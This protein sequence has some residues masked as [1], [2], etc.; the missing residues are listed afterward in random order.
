MA[1]YDFDP[2][3]TGFEQP[4]TMTPRGQLAAYGGTPAPDYTPPT[5]YSTA[6]GTG[7]G[8]VALG[9]GGELP[10]VEAGVMPS[11]IGLGRQLGLPAAVM[12]ALGIAGGA[13]AGYQALGGGEGEGIFGMDVL[14]GNG[15][16]IPGTQIGLGGP[17]LAEPGPGTG[18][19]LLKEWHVNYDWG[20]LQYYLIQKIGA[21]GR[22]SNRYIAMYNT[23]TSIWKAWRWVP[24]KLAVIGKNMPRHQMLTRLRRNLS[25][26]K[27]D[28]KTLLKYVDPLGYAKDRGYR[29]YGK[30]R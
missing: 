21:V 18:W 10:E 30:R 14:G 11:V 25:R 6:P 23:R 12:T 15:Q 19:N 20:R 29:H 5:R 24:P 9:P 7:P 4:S 22:Y 3:M 8:G 26:H 28:A 2:V 1:I 27:Q 16:R 17:G 13:Y